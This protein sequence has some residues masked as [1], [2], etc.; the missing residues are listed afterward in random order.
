MNFK[1]HDSAKGFFSLLLACGDLNKI[2]RIWVK[3]I[4]LIFVGFAH[5]E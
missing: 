4:E 5:Y 2:L 3:V 1:S